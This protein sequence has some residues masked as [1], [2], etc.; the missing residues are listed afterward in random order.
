MEEF[1]ESMKSNP[2]IGAFSQLSGFWPKFNKD[3]GYNT[4]IK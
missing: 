1:N 3:E 4:L 2:L